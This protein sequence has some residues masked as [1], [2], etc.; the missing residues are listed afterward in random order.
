MK[1][2]TIC[3]VCHRLDEDDA[4]IYFKCKEVKKIWSGLCMQDERTQLATITG[5]EKGYIQHTKQARNAITIWAKP[6]QVC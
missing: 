5:I 1:L 4:H 6:A 2:D 3:L